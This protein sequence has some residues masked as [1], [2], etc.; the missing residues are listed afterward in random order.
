MDREQTLQAI[1]KLKR[2]IPMYTG[3]SLEGEQFETGRMTVLRRSLQDIFEHSLED[4]TIWEWL[5]TF[6]ITS[7]SSMRYQGWAPNR[8]YPKDHPKYDPQKPEKTKHCNDTNW[9][10]YY[11]IIIGN[12]EYWVNVKNHK[13]FGE[14]VYVIEHEKPIDLITGHKKK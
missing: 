3:I 1:K 6:D 4:K 10:N 7:L 8:T 13:N 5:Q 11:T 12:T 14:V 9:F 2:S